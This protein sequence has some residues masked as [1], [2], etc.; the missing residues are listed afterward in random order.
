MR[1]SVSVV[2]NVSKAETGYPNR[3]DRISKVDIVVPN[4]INV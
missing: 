2:V 4:D 3:L 1:I